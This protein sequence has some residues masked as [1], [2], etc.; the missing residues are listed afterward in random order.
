V[1]AV[2]WWRRVANEHADAALL[3]RLAAGEADLGERDQAL[4]S[5]DRAATLQPDDPRVAR[6]RR[7]LAPR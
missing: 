3:L 1:R 4:A 5:L 7:Q 2:Y 6:L